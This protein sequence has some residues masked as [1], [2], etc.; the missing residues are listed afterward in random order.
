LAGIADQAY[1]SDLETMQPKPEEIEKFISYMKMLNDNIGVYEIDG[2]KSNWLKTNK[3]LIDQYN[4]FT[5]WSQSERQKYS[6]RFNTMLDTERG[7]ILQKALVALKNAEIAAAKVSFPRDERV[8]EAK[9][10]SDAPEG[11]EDT[12]GETSNQTPSSEKPRRNQ[13]SSSQPSSSQSISRPSEEKPEKPEYN[14]ASIKSI[15]ERIEKLKEDAE[16]NRELSDEDKETLLHGV[17]YGSCC[18]IFPK[19]KK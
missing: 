11:T 8:K 7:A 9:Y 18:V 1:Y 4:E 14:F 2:P 6:S 10:M 19:S 5:N 13:P 12:S 15:E 17:I 16:E 3:Q